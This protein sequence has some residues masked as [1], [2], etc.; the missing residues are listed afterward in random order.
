MTMQL[1][2]MTDATAKRVQ[3][4][5]RQYP[6]ANSIIAGQQAVNRVEML[7]LAEYVDP[8]YSAYIMRFDGSSLSVVGSN[9]VYVYVL[10]NN[11]AMYML[12]VEQG[13][14]AGIPVF[15]AACCVPF[16]PPM[17]GSGCQF[18]CQPLP[19]QFCL[20]FTL[21]QTDDG[22]FGCVET[23]STT[24]T[25]TSQTWQGTYTYSTCGAC[26]GSGPVPSFDVEF[27]CN[28]DFTLWTKITSP[29]TDPFG[30]GTVLLDER[31]QINSC[32][33]IVGQLYAPPGGLYLSGGS[34]CA[35]VTTSSIVEGSC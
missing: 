19:E 27:Y 1:Y 26:G 16:E 11:P 32:P 9:L 12:G 31:M 30:T 2:G 22:S 8:Y 14:D 6:V 20:S 18:N 23:G 29:A 10:D 17:S 33:P 7:M 13:A 24:L 25:P 28:T 4:L 3:Q 5:T 35:Y 21:T 34:M 15:L